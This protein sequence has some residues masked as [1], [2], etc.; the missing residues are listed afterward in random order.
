M[1]LLLDAVDTAP[2][3]VNRQSD[4]LEDLRLALAGQA[5]L[6]ID[7]FGDHEQLGFSQWIEDL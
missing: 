7:R 4:D 1:G 2:H 6:R 3:L 5:R